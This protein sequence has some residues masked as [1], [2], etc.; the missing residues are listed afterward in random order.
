MFNRDKPKINLAYIAERCLKRK[1]KKDSDDQNNKKI[2][3]LQF[4]VDELE[5]KR[6]C[7]STIIRKQK[8]ENRRLATLNEQ[9]FVE[10]K[11]FIE[12]IK[13]KSIQNKKLMESKSN[14]FSNIMEMDR[15]LKNKLEKRGSSLD[16]RGH[17]L[18]RR[19]AALDQK[20][21][22]YDLLGKRN[23]KDKETIETMNNILNQERKKRDEQ[24]QMIKVQYEQTINQFRQTLHNIEEEIKKKDTILKDTMGAIERNNTTI[25]DQKG[26]IDG[27][28]NSCEMMHQS[29]DE[30]LFLFDDYDNNRKDIISRENDIFED[31]DLF[32]LLNE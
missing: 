18:D 3:S 9:L 5:K 16:Q 7:D 6:D 27:W 4:A 15:K 14:R 25:S 10:K 28:N 17:D 20:K 11:E 2:R 29:L 8:E 1:R 32:S 12:V 22:E 26:I 24:E 31:N 13:V 23:K 21:I 19:E 30:K